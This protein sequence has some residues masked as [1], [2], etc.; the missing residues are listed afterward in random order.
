[1]NVSWKQSSA[2][3]RPTEATRKRH[4]SSRWA[5]RKRWNGGGVTRN[6]RR[7][8]R[9][10]ETRRTRSPAPRRSPDLGRQPPEHRRGAI[11]LLA[12]LDPERVEDGERVRRADLLKPRE[13]PAGVVEAEDHPV[14]D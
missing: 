12:Q 6:R 14:V 10:R 7:R 9:F 3:S 11:A 4:T 5:S 8:G 13:R 1:M 2:A